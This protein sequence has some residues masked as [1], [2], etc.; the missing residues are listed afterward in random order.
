MWLIKNVIPY[1]GFSFYKIDYKGEL[2][3]SLTRAYTRIDKLN[4]RDLRKKFEKKREK[5]GGIFKWHPL[6][7][8]WK[9]E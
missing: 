9:S 7:I 1:N 3:K 4:E 6:S 2:P 8:I 5:N